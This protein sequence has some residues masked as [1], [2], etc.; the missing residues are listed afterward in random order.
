MSCEYNT[1]T[2]TTT[3]PYIHSFTHTP[4]RHSSHHQPNRTKPNQIGPNQ[5]NPQSNG[6]NGRT[7][8]TAQTPKCRTLASELTARLTLH[9]TPLVERRTLVANSCKVL[10]QESANHLLCF[11]LS[12]LAT[13]KT[14]SLGHL[15]NPRYMAQDHRPQAASLAAVR[16]CCSWLG[17]RRV[18]CSGARVLG[19][20]GGWAIG[21]LRGRMLGRLGD[22]WLVCLGCLGGR[23]HG[24]M[25]WWSSAGVVGWLRVPLRGWSGG[26]GGWAVGCWSG[27]VNRW[28]GAWALGCL[29]SCCWTAGCS[30][31]WMAGWLG[32]WVVGYVGGHA[33]STQ[34][35]D[36]PSAAQAPLSR[37][38]DST[39]SPPR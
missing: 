33:G 29:G 23:V 20:L 32:V 8:P 28:S 13:L 12:C 16:L 18:G 15:S 2:H 39:I 34:A 6:K 30:D 21:R 22:C 17:D 7:T 37:T 14:M 35:L 10:Y 11:T 1:S 4:L 25:V 24:W 3:T 31:G 26:R 36:H 38:V 27:Q 19:W 9:A 5:T